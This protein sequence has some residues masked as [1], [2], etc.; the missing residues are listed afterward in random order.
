M[1]SIKRDLVIRYDA[2]KDCFRLFPQRVDLVG[3]DS[4]KEVTSFSVELPLEELR[5]RIKDSEKLIGAS[6]LSFFDQLNTTGLGLRPYKAEVRNRRNRDIKALLKTA[7]DADSQYALAVQFLNK[8]TES[9][10]KTDIAESEKW[11]TKAADSGSKVARDFL[12]GDWKY[13]KSRL[14]RKLSKPR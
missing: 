3:D 7:H 13:I 1:S 11:L 10:R 8:A 6:V 9:G 12:D 14:L 2:Q 4:T 5:K